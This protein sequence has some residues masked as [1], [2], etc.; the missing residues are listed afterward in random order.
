VAGF[1]AGVALDA[2]AGVAPAGA[3]PRCRD[4]RKSTSSLTL[5]RLG[6]DVVWS[7]SWTSTATATWKG[8]PTSRSRDQCG[9]DGVVILRRRCHDGTHMVRGGQ[10]EQ[11]ISRS[12]RADPASPAYT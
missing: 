2:E 11:D 8:T 4:C 12:G 3:A 5:T 7:W 6:V 10:Q 1:G 9:D